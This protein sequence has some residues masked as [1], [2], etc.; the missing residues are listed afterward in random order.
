MSDKIRLRKIILV[1]NL[2]VIISSI[3]GIVSNRIDSERVLGVWF[4][5][6]DLHEAETIIVYD[7]MHNE[8]LRY[9]NNEI[10]NLISEYEPSRSYP[11]YKREFNKHLGELMYTVEVVFSDDRNKKDRPEI[12]DSTIEILS[13][14]A[15]DAEPFEEQSTYEKYAINIDGQDCVVV[16]RNILLALGN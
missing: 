2:F 3:W 7:N 15:L 1:L 6:D 13:I 4:F 12:K 8:V 16:L 9:G 10:N 14:Y 5:V 11:K